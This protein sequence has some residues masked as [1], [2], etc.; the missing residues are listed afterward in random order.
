ML[1]DSAAQRRELI[2]G[3]QAAPQIVVGLFDGDILVEPGQVVGGERL[4][5]QI[6]QDDRCDQDDRDQHADLKEDGDEGIQ[7]FR[8][9]LGNEGAP[10]AE[11]RRER[12]GAWGVYC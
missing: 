11:R 8:L 3:D 1:E 7:G 2:L 6:G 5:L 12:E 9:S 4:T 10:A